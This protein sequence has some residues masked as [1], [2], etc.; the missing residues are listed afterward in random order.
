MYKHV[1]LWKLKEEADGKSRKELALEVKRRLDALPAHISEI[2]GF[3]TAINI[4]DYGASFFDVSIVAVFDTKDTF[5]A[6][7]KYPIH[8]EVCYFL[9]RPSVKSKTY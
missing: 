4:G 6:Y 2:K 1:V 3:E 9:K 7:T 8:D 5:W